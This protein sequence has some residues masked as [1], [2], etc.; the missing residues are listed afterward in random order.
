MS[1]T[2]TSADG[3]VIAFD[4]HGPADGPAVVL[5]HGATA[6]RAVQP[7]PA[8]IAELT[9]FRV[10]EYDRRGRGESGDTLP[11]AVEREV[12]DIAA[13]VEH[14]GGT[15]WLLGESSG[16]T[17]ALEAARAGVPAIGLLLYEPP[18]VADGGRPR[19]PADF[20]ERLDAHLAGGRRDLAFRQFS[21]E[22]VGMPE[23]MVG[24]VTQSPYW[25]F[26]EPVAHTL[27]YD[28]RVCGDTM[29]G[30][31]EPLQRFAGVRVPTTILV[32]S[33]TFPY[34]HSGAAALADALPDARV[35]TL[36]GADHQLRAEVV[37]PV[38]R[39]TIGAD[40]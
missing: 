32:G 13:L 25:G 2:I 11:Y 7:A 30:S 36:D 16:A 6:S 37:A 17:L 26:V 4:V 40:R 24:D 22:G 14:L 9:G 38:L 35:V 29:S 18:I 15:A 33:A 10:L 3:T 12:D 8:A 23:D 31:P 28:A 34:M 20:I 19:V 39:D 5:V 1:E 27:A 21:I